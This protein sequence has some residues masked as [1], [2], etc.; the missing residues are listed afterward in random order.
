M[1]EAGSGREMQAMGTRSCRA[2][3]SMMKTLALPW[4]GGEQEKSWECFADK[5]ELA[6]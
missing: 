1:A 4:F 2:L 5:I 6:F 3:E